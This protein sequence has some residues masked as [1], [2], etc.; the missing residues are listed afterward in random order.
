VGVVVA[1]GDKGERNKKQ[2][3]SKAGSVLVDALGKVDSCCGLWALEPLTLK[4]S[5]VKHVRVSD[6]LVDVCVFRLR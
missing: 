4:A 5:D 2:L 1:D 6:A 3:G